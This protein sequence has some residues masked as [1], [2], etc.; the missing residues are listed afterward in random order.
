MKVKLKIVV[1]NENVIF[2]SQKIADQLGNSVL[3]C[4][5][6]LSA[7]AQVK[8]KDSVFE[9]D[10]N[11]EKGFLSE[12]CPEPILSNYENNQDNIEENTEEI[13]ISSKLK[14]YLLIKERLTYQI[15]LFH[16]RII[17]GPVIGLLLRNDSRN[18]N[19]GFI[20]NNKKRF[21]YYKNI[22][23]LFC[24]FS[25]MNINFKSKTAKGYYYNFNKSKWATGEFPLPEV[26]YRRHFST[27]NEIIRKLK[28]L[29]HNKIFNSYRFNKFE[30]YKYLIEDPVL[31]KHV[32]VTE[33]CSSIPQIEDFLKKHKNI[34]LKPIDL[35]R[36]RGICII[37]S[38]DTHFR[39]YDYRKKKVHITKLP[40]HKALSLFLNRN[41]SFLSKYIMQEL[42]PLARINNNPY[43]IRVVMHKT[44][45]GIWENLGIECRVS[46]GSLITNISRGGYAL[47]LKDAIAKSF[48]KKET[49]KIRKKINDLCRRICVLI[50]K[51]TGEHYAEFGMDIGIDTKKKLWII[52][53]NVRPSYDGFKDIDINLYNLIRRNPLLYAVSLTE[54][55]DSVVK[56]GT[57]I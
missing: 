8:I 46:R 12:T 25:P 22:G 16:S 23:G 45:A 7:K 15:R 52:E 2:V 20:K 31:S 41:K 11:S 19:A 30:L 43:D 37:H 51:S 57:R 21:S 14:E 40:S 17:I 24:V 55:K 54:F 50:E 47:K 18:N 33:V 48:G 3:I 38:I 36:G 53:V 5:G 27:N 35:S 34:I 49:K 39:V 13:I 32:P 10:R 42:I 4:F 29:T 56:G 28:K 44:P 9:H 6:C 26:I 1:L